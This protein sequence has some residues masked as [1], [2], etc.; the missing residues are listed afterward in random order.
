MHKDYRDAHPG[1]AWDM[2][3]LKLRNE[4]HTLKEIAEK[5]GHKNHSGVQKHIRKTGEAYEKKFL[6]LLKL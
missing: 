2:E 6:L 4:G 1:M 3:I 5:Q